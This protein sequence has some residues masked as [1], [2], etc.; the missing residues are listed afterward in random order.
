MLYAPSKLLTFLAQ[1][2][3]AITTG[4][5]HEN[6]VP[7]GHILMNAAR[8]LLG[9]GT[10]QGDFLRGRFYATL[11][12]DDSIS[13]VYARE[14]LKLDGKVVFQVDRATAMELALDG[15]RYRAQYL[16]MDEE[17]LWPILRDKL[18]DLQ[19]MPLDQFMLKLARATAS[20]AAQPSQAE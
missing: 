14:N 4:F 11:D 8:P 3:V 10:F 16:E 18:H 15:C 12:P 13:E 2:P 17:D 5:E 9:Q 20:A 7:T 6:V 1:A 19:N